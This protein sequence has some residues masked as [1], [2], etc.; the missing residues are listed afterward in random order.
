MRQTLKRLWSL[1][2]LLGGCAISYLYWPT[3]LGLVGVLSSLLLFLPLVIVSLNDVRRARNFQSQPAFLEMNLPQPRPLF[4]GPIADALDR[5][6]GFVGTLEGLGLLVT[7]V[8]G[9]GL[10][11]Y[12]AVAWLIHFVSHA[13]YLAAGATGLLG[14]LAVAV[15]LARIPA[16]LIVVLG[17]AAVCGTAFLSGYGN[18]LLP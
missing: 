16:A 14:L 3:A 1:P 5:I 15:A 13:Q 10:F 2:L 4:V 18:A 6:A 8:A 17:S 11:G 12:V 9:V 7:V